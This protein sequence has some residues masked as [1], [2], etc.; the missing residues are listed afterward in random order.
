VVGGRVRQDLVDDVGP[1]DTERV[2]AV[3]GAPGEEDLEVE[4]G[5]QAGM[6]L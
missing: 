4:G 6:K 1:T 5:V 3:V 2:Q